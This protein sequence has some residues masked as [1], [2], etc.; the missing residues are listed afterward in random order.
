MIEC[1]DQQKSVLQHLNERTG[2]LFKISKDP[3]VTRLGSFLRKHSIDE[4]PQLWNVL[5]RDMSLVGPRPPEF[6][7]LIEYKLEHLR[8]L[9]AIP[10]ITGLWQVSARHDPYFETAVALDNHYIE[11]WSLML[12][13]KIILKTVPVVL[14]GL[15]R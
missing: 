5:K 9:D 12:D 4:L 3:R 10:G 2:P 14:K 15:G 11:N 6:D 1:A 13:L 7:E 8:R